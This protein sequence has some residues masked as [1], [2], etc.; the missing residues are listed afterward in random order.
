MADLP[1]DFSQKRRFEVEFFNLFGVPFDSVT[2]VVELTSELHDDGMSHYINTK[3]KDV[4]SHDMF[5]DKWLEKNAS[6]KS[7][8][9]RLT[10]MFSTVP[11]DKRHIWG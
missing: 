8:M 1:D 9:K 6:Q 4:Y 2:S 10:N 3:T 5:K 11:K 7:V